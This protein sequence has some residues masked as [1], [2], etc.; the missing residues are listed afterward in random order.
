VVKR[1]AGIETLVRRVAYL[2]RARV[3][4]RKRALEGLRERAGDVLGCLHRAPTL[5][6]Y[7]L[8]RGASVEGRLRSDFC[9]SVVV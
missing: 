3:A 7:A 4:S 8:G 2:H 9:T 6:L 5:R 1:L